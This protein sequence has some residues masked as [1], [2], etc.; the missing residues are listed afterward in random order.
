[1]KYFLFIIHLLL[2]FILFF[3][4]ETVNGLFILYYINIYFLLK[5]AYLIYKED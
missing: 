3:N 4:I 5:N 1:M 2:F